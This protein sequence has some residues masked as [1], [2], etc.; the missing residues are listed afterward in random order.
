[1]AAT[2]FAGPCVSETHNLRL[3]SLF[4]VKCEY[5]K[6]ELMSCYFHNTNKK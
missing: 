6:D 1:M 2:V 5:I 4:C 3:N